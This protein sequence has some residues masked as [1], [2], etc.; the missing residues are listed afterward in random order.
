MVIRVQTSFQANDQMGA[1]EVSGMERNEPATSQELFPAVNL[2][3]CPVWDRLYATRDSGCFSGLVSPGPMNGA[4][5][6]KNDSLAVLYC[7]AWCKNDSRCK[8]EKPRLVVP[9]PLKA[10]RVQLT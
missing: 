1:C 6:V 2:R 10:S 4:S 9:Q 5:A 8:K 7:K 3:S